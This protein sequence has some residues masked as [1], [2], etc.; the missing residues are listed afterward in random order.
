MIHGTEYSVEDA[1]AAYEFVAQN[2]AFKDGIMPELPPSP[3]W[4]RW[5]I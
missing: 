2:G 5:D 3:E 1:K 4:V